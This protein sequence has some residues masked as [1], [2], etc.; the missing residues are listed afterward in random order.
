MIV[1]GVAEKRFYDRTKT[2]LGEASVLSVVL[3]LEKG[4]LE[5]RSANPVFRFLGHRDR[6]GL[7]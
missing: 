3:P 5:P 6:G 4:S 7:L 2:E 1:V